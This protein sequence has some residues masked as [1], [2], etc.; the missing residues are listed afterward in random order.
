M[1]ETEIH[2]V[3]QT[4]KGDKSSF[5][6][7]VGRYYGAVYG[8]AYHWTKDF[9]EAQDLTQDTFFQAYEEL[10]CLKEPE[11]FAA[12]LRSIATN[13]CRM[14]RRSLDDKTESI[15]APWNR[16]LLEELLHPGDQPEKILEVK[17]RQKVLDEILC[18]LTDPVRLTVT[19]F[20]IDDL[21]YQEISAFLG[22]PISTVKIR[23][24]KARNKL[25]KEA[26]KMVEETFG[27]QKSDPKVEIKEVEGFLHVHEHGY[28]F[29]RP[30]ED[31][32]SSPDDIYVSHSQIERF[33][34]SQGDCI[35]GHARPPKGL[36]HGEKYFALIR[37]ERVNDH[38]AESVT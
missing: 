31:A 12:W 9:M 33:E 3:Q 37:F 10:D 15:D 22:V 36:E 30:T 25:K 14:W 21:S 5:D 27:H 35:T 7:L 8:L 34:L 11:K 13:F 6:R 23:L 2:L 16:K 29:L 1:D 26:L 19:L 24:H 38:A 32:P 17:E 4:L 18:L 28:G 20:Y